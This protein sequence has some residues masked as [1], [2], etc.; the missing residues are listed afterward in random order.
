MPLIKNKTDN[1]WAAGCHLASLIGFVIPLGS[2]LGP[3]VVWILKKETA[4]VVN[5]NGKESLNFQISFLIYEV[6]LMI[7]LC[8]LCLA[9]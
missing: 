3:L 2:I 5:E 8:F 7:F 9:F 4:K 1:A 6:A